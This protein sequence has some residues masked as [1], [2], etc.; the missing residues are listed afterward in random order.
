[1][2]KDEV[3]RLSTYEKECQRK[4]EIINQLYHEIETFKHRHVTPP[5]TLLYPADIRYPD[6][7]DHKLSVLDNELSAKQMEIDELKQQVTFSFFLTTIFASVLH[8]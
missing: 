6:G 4:D 5:G 8:N 2:L 7:P 1:M 3:R